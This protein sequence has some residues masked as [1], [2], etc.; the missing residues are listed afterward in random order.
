MVAPF[1]LL[2]ASFD[3][4]VTD[5]LLPRVVKLRLAVNAEL[6]ATTSILSP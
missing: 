3:L 4:I 2:L 5:C 1:K 6:S